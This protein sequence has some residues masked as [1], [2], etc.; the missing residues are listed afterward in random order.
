MKKILVLLLTALV[1]I[2]VF[3]NGQQDESE[4]SQEK[5]VLSVGFWDINAS[6]SKDNKDA[7]TLFIEDKFNVEIV[8]RSFSW[9]D[10]TEKTLLWGA[11]GDLP[12]VFASDMMLQDVY[13]QW[14]EEGLLRALPENLSEYPNVQAV[15]ELETIKPLS[16]DGKYYLFPRSN[17]VDSSYNSASRGILVRKDWME[18]LG[19]EKP[20]TFEEFLAMGKAFVEMDPDGNGVDDTIGMTF[21]NKYY[22]SM[23]FLSSVPEAASKTW[24]FEEG[25]WIP[26][27]ASEDMI[28][29][30]ME[31][32]TLWTE[33]VMDP[34]TLSLSS[35]QGMERFCKGKTGMLFYQASP[36]KINK[37]ATLWAKYNDTELVD[38]IDTLSIW[39]NDEG[40]RYAFHEGK[41]FWSSSYFSSAVSDE[42]MDRILEIY[43]Y[44][45]SEEGQNALKYGIPGVDFTMEGDKV[46]RIDISNMIEKYR[47]IDPIGSLPQ[48]SGGFSNWVKDEYSLGLYP[49]SVMDMCMDQ[50]LESKDILSPVNMAVQ[51]LNTPLKGQFERGDAIFDTIIVSMIADDP[52]AV[53]N[54]QMAQLRA[55]G[56]DEAITEVNVKIKELGIK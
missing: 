32:N 49:E 38:L 47:S 18:K 56:L 24:K 20:E 29:G 40:N 53:W 11:S 36:G 26:G 12:D 31:L 4:A 50:Y 5:M 14:I 7:F 33:G 21:S 55:E 9:G 43:E 41:N 17:S 27:Y 52:V 28:K 25:Q 13:Y 2:S 16:I 46:V 22:T 45:I 15:T 37:L 48:W 42:K 10:Y 23:A 19:L 30:I 54:K 39:T 35:S 6:I 3:A 34:D 1:S 8:E 51:Y 44:L